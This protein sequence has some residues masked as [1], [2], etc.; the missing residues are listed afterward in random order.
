MLLSDAKRQQVANPEDLKAY[1]PTPQTLHKKT[2]FELPCEGLS[3]GRQAVRS[4]LNLC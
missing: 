2:T 1:E 4:Q 3:E